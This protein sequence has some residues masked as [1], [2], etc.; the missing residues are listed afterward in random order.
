M[1]LTVDALY[2]PPS[3]L[4]YSFAQHFEFLE[5]RVDFFQSVILPADNRIGTTKVYS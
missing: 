4:V 2:A 1:P 3:T 5:E